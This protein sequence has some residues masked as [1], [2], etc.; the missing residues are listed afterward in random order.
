[1]LFLSILRPQLPVPYTFATTM[2]TG[3]IWQVVV[4]YNPG[5][6]YVLARSCTTLAEA[7]M[8]ATIALTLT[9]LKFS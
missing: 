3:V 9:P 6:G 4:T 1:M 2:R 7:A 5:W 8:V